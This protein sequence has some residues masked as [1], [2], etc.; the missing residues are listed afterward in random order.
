M[1]CVKGAQH[2]FLQDFTQ[3]LKRA[4]GFY[5]NTGRQGLIF[6]HLPQFCFHV[7]RTKDPRP[8]MQIR[9]T[10]MKNRFSQHL[11]LAKAADIFAVSVHVVYALRHAGFGLCKHLQLVQ[12]LATFR[13]CSDSRLLTGCISEGQ[14]AIVY[15]F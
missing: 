7:L 2:D 6:V 8:E 15:A 13:Q 14:V 10:P 5:S 11:H 12:H 3:R 4:A 9:R 1:A